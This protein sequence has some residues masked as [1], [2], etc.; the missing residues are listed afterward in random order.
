L[1]NEI[2]GYRRSRLVKD[3]KKDQGAFRS[4]PTFDF[5]EFS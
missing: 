5:Q 2:L 3:I 1:I 4:D